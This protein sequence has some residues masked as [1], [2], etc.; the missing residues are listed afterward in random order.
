MHEGCAW[1]KWG[2]ASTNGKHLLSACHWG[3]SQAWEEWVESGVGSGVEQTL[4][5]GLRE[6][7][8]ADCACVRGRAACRLVLSQNKKEMLTNW[9][10]EGKLEPSE[11]LGDL[12]SAA[13]KCSTSRARQGQ[14][15]GWGRGRGRNGPGWGSAR[16][17]QDTT[18]CYGGLWQV[19]IPARPGNCS[20]APSHPRCT[21][22]DWHAL[23]LATLCCSNS[24]EER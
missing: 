2:W 3:P 21:Q 13:G 11:E 6:C 4:A 1:G 5:M 15:P 24:G 22:L 18:W 14:G 12:V 23:P 7:L 16:A 19:E 10:N 8:E 17:A 20:W 9:Y